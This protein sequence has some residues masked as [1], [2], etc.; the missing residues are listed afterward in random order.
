[1]DFIPKQYKSGSFEGGIK[2]RGIII[3]E[4]K[5]N[6]SL[7]SK[8]IVQLSLGI[9]VVSLI[10]FGAVSGYRFYLDKKVQNVRNEISTIQNTQDWALVE[11]LIEVQKMD[12]TVGDIKYSHIRTSKFFEMLDSATLP[13]VQWDNINLSIDLSPETKL[14]TV[15]LH[16]KTSAPSILEKQMN[17]FTENNFDVVDIGSYE[18]IGDN[19][20]G[21]P[22]R[23]TLRD[24]EK[25]LDRKR[26]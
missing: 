24:I 4:K 25:L 17:K 6:L 15:I 7:F 26:N 19:K 18:K 21:F 23:V 22:S 12:A 1:M 16:G 13:E 10:V 20:I 11:K 5:I 3:S 8:R 2:S 14:A 9:V